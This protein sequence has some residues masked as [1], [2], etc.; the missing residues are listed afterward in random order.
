VRAIVKPVAGSV[1]V[2]VDGRDVGVD[3]DATTGVVTLAVAPPPGAVVSAG[4]RFHVPV[5]FDS[6]ELTIDLAAFAA[7]ELPSIPIVE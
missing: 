2:A 3:V 7:G 6:D 5:R 4:F 1:L